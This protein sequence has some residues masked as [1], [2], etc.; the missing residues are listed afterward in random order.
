MRSHNSSQRRIW[1]GSNEWFLVRKLRMDVSHPCSFSYPHGWGLGDA[2]KMI[3]LWQRKPPV[4]EFLLLTLR[5]G[6]KVKF[7]KVTFRSVK[8]NHLLSFQARVRVRVG[9]DVGIGVGVRIK[10]RVRFLLLEN[11]WEVDHVPFQQKSIWR[12]VNF[13]KHQEEAVIPPFLKLFVLGK[14]FRWRLEP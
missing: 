14:P 2:Y 3:E 6:N 13:T 1:V 5:K 8:K 11:N 10:G 12:I 9:V 4:S 7:I